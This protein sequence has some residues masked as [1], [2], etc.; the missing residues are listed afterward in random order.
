MILDNIRNCMLSFLVE[1]RIYYIYFC[2]NIQ[3]IEHE[4]G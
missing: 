2:K 1:F 4:V 3:H